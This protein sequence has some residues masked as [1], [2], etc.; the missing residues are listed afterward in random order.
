MSHEGSPL[1]AISDNVGGGDGGTAAASMEIPSI[2]V[3]CCGPLPETI[4]RLFEKPTLGFFE[5]RQYLSA[6]R[7]S[8]AFRRPFNRTNILQRNAADDAAEAATEAELNKLSAELV[9][10][11]LSATPPPAAT[12]AKQQQHA[13]EEEETT[14]AVVNAAAIIEEDKENNV[15]VIKNPI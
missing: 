1:L 14:Q 12:A 8:L 15:G 4:E 3:G 10:G 2:T 5:R 6:S 11:V 13:E 9:E 7:R